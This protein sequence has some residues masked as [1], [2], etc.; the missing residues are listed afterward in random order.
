LV[1]NDKNASSYIMSITAGYF[2]PPTLKGLGCSEAY[3]KSG[4]LLYFL[5]KTWI[6]G[7]VHK[8]FSVEWHSYKKNFTSGL[9]QL[10][11]FEESVGRLAQCGE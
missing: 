5:G 11:A 2:L 4:I 6:K 10:Q 3:S 8:T 1:S 9:S 7:S